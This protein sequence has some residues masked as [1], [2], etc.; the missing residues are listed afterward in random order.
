V[1]VARAEAEPKQAATKAQ[2][3]DQTRARPIWAVQSL[4]T[5]P[6]GERTLSPTARACPHRRRGTD[7]TGPAAACV[8]HTKLAIVRKSDRTWAL[9]L[10]AATTR[11]HAPVEVRPRACP[12]LEVVDRRLDLGTVQTRGIAPVPAAK[13]NRV[14]IAPAE[15]NPVEIVRKLDRVEALDPRSLGPRQVDPAVVRQPVAA[16]HLRVTLEISSAFRDPFSPTCD[17]GPEHA[18]IAPES[19]ARKASDP[20]DLIGPTWIDRIA[21]VAK[22]PI[23]PTDRGFPAAKFR[24]DPVKETAP[25]VPAALTAPVFPRVNAPVGLTDPVF[26]KGND[27]RDPSVQTK[28]TGPVAPVNGPRGRPAPV[29]ANAPSAPADRN[30]PID[31]TRAGGLAVPANDQTGRIV[32]AMAVPTMPIGPGTTARIVATTT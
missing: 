16:A 30:G 14:E 22:D 20:L 25:S 12:T 27:R 32:R 4:R 21:L 5:D 26:R 8:H 24:A 19:I 17:R 11:S 10:E 31:P 9:V 13:I 29:K 18:R 3:L 1:E 28:A 6:K 2:P 15:T 23:A 7:P